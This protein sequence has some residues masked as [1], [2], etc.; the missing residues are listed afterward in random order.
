MHRC[1]RLAFLF[2]L[3]PLSQ[4]MAQSVHLPPVVAPPLPQGRA[5]L[6]IVP[7]PGGDHGLV[8]NGMVRIF[9]GKLWVIS[10][11]GREQSVEL[12]GRTLAEVATAMR[13]TF[14]GARVWTPF[15]EYDGR[16]LER[17]LPTTLKTSDT[18]EVKED[19]GGPRVSA[20]LGALFALADVNDASRG[21]RLLQNAGAQFDLVA[22]YPFHRRAFLRLRLGFAGNDP[23]AI[24]EQDSTAGGGAPGT[25]TSVQG[26]IENAERVALG[27]LLDYYLINRSRLKVGVGV[28]Y[29]MAWN[30]F[31]PFQLPNVV[32]SVGQAINVASLYPANRVAAVL[33]RVNRVLPASTISGQ[34]SLVF[35][36]ESGLSAYAVFGVGLTERF[37]RRVVFNVVANPD[38]ATLQDSTQSDFKGIWRLGI[39]MTLG[40]VLDLRAD[41]VGPLDADDDVD[42][43]LRLYVSKE[44]TLK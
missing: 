9:G 11:D 44:F 18:I 15:P 31:D 24:L 6:V 30:A 41:A 32:D 2:L 19:L 27:G 20:T 43:L 7:D 17:M 4:A 35:P 3:G 26:I 12:A 29:E 37:S 39:G 36:A 21:R 25:G 38:P 42:P 40:S 13:G 16:Y 34:A 14:A 1:V 28:E 10:P 23:Q 5:L 8:P 33:A 22:E